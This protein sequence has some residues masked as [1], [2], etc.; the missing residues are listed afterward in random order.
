MS[1]AKAPNGSRRWSGGNVSLTARNVL[2]SLVVPGLGAV[3]VPWWIL[4]GARA[5]PGRE[6]GAR[7]CD[8]L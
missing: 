8:S 2:F 4:D 3:L 6:E 7:Q 1:T 5:A